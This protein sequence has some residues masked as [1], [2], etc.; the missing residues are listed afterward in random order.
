MK[1]SLKSILV[2]LAGALG[3]L[4]FF[5]MFA[6]Q[7]VLDS[8]LGTH[9]IPF[10]EVMFGNGEGMKGAIGT[11]IGYMF[12]LVPSIGFLVSGIAALTGKELGVIDVIIH[13]LGV[14]M[15]FIGMVLVFCTVKMYITANP[16]YDGQAGNNLSLGGG[17]ICGGIFS[18]I[19]VI[20]AVAGYN[21]DY[22]L[23]K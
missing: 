10:A 9:V 20:G 7:I 15:M 21:I 18:L 22:K 5:M 11:F 19:G 1:L 3:L 12:I 16:I 14:V 13:Y 23:G 8:V 2:T 4:A 6:P 17:S